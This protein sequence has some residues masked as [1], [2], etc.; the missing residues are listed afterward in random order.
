V[1]P[2]DVEALIREEQARQGGAF[3]AENVPLE[4]YLGKLGSRAEIAAHSEGTTCQTV[5]TCA[6]P[7]L[8]VGL[9]TQEPSR[10][11]FAHG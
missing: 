6:A 10:S 1:L 2:A 8:E 7:L 4:E 11:S 9:K 3:I 5:A